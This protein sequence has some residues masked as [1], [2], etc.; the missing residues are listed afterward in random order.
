MGCAHVFVGI[1][2]PLSPGKLHSLNIQRR[3]NFG[4]PLGSKMSDGELVEGLSVETVSN[5]GKIQ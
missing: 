2:N 1:T 5:L 3:W 4:Y